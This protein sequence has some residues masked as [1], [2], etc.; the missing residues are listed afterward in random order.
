MAVYERIWRP[1][2]GEMTAVFLRFLVI[3]RFA[4]RE[5]FSS[6][7]FLAFYAACSFPTLIGFVI[8]YLHH[9]AAMLEK[10]GITP[11]FVGEL[12]QAFFVHLFPWQ[13]TPAFLIAVIVSPNLIA[14]DV[15]N[16]ALPMYLAR[17][18]S[19]TGYFL[20]K[21][22][23]LFILISPVTWI[24]GLLVFSL[25]AYFAGLG[26]A[27]SNVRIAMAYFV[28]HMI[29]I[30]VISLLTLAISAW[31]RIK[32]VARGVLFGIIFILAG[33]GNAINAMT[34]T[35]WGTMFNIVDSCI[36]VVA[37]LFDPTQV[38]DLPTWAAG[39]SLAAVSV[40]SLFLLRKKLRA[41]EVVS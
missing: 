18:L 29:W 13:A 34:G 4:L 25:Q 37:R 30:T 24:G 17:P 28:G 15:T 2:E 9:N 8:V 36:I 14:A 27:Q 20:G 31:V 41:H 22:A 40:F 32:P 19:R 21:M 10:I 7:F 1:Y 39:L 6:R 3:T 12:T 16:N 5:V 35:R 33:L 38:Q 26:W 11:G 23:V